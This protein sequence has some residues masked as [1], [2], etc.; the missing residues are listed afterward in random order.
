MDTCG[1]C[2][3]PRTATCDHVAVASSEVS[4]V[5]WWAAPV[6]PADAPGLVE[7]LDTH[8]LD[9]LG[10][11][12]R[13]ADRARYLAAHALARLVLA[14]R[15]PPAELVYDR[16]CRCGAQHG[17]PVL[18]GGPA[19]SLTHAADL[20]GVAV[21]DGPV[22]LDVEQVRPMSDL[23]GMAAHVCS[24]AET[25]TDAAS[26]F[27]VWTRKEALLKATGDGLSSPMAAITLGPSGVRE[28]TG[29]G[30][31]ARPVWLRD[32][33]PAPGYRA[34]VAGFGAAAPEVVETDGNPLLRAVC[35]AGPA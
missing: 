25:V 19:F 15:R 27:T 23:A 21:H 4:C 13:A 5:V 12:R 34:A 28:W 17:K 32:L 29:D 7:L 31:P 16:S 24:P 20:V 9:R 30:A 3:R 35:A 11:F 1:G 10:R 14:E 2:G 22:G 26:F 6:E 8:E 33:H 18:P